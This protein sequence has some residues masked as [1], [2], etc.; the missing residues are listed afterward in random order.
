MRNRLF[1]TSAIVL[2]MAATPALAQSAPSDSAIGE[3]VVTAQKRSENIQ[4]VPIAISAFT[5]MALK[6][7]SVTSVASLSSLTPN[8]NLDGG[9]PFSGSSAVLSATIRGIGSDDFAFNIDP[10]VGIYLDGVY[11][12]RTVGANQDLPDVERVEILKGPQGTLFGRNTIG[13]A[14]SIV[15]HDPGKVFKG[16]FDATTGSF[17]MV[18]LRATVDVPLTHSLFS[19]LTVASLNRQGFL[20]RIPFP[21]Q[22][23]GN[24]DP[25]TSFSHADYSSASR[26]GGDNSVSLRGKLKWDNGGAITATFTGDFT[27]QDSPS[28][29][30]KLLGVFPNVPG[31][32][33]GTTNLPGTAF[34]PTSS[35]GFL[36]AGLY[37]FCIN[38]T[39]SQI[40]GRNA[41]GLCGP[42]GTQF[43]P[44]YQ[45]AGLGSVNT[46]S[47]PLNN[48]LPWDSR[49][50]IADPDL[51]YATG[52]SFTK[53]TA[54]GLGGTVQA[55]VS[56]NLTIKSITA[57]RQTNW[58]G[59]VDAD[60]SPLSFLEL[61]FTQ[62]Q[63]QLSQELQL[64]GKAFDKKLNYVLG[65]YYFKEKGD[66][67]D[68]VVFTEGLLQV[69]GLNK[70]NTENWAV[71]G[72]VDFRPSDLLGFTVGGRYTKERKAFEGGQQ[73]LNG[74][75]YKLFGCSDGAG[76]ITPGGPFPLA[77]VSCQ[78]ALGYPNPANPVQVYVPGV[79][80][81]SFSNFS[82]KLGVQ[83]HPA[84]DIMVYGSWSKG[85]KTGGWTTRLTNPQGNVAPDFNEEK[86]TTLE[87]GIKS[88]LLDRHLQINLAA[89]TTAYKGVQLNIQ[90]G[91]SPTIAN[92]G[93]ARI[94]G[95]EL[96][97]VAAPIRG[98]TINGA[99]GYIDAHYT[100]LLPAALVNASPIPGIQEGIFVGA[101][102]PKT[103]DWKINVSPRYEYRMASG[104]SLVALGDWTHT[105][106][107]WN[108]IAR[109]DLLRRPANDMFNASLAYNAPEGR[110]SI[111]LGA[112]NLTNT[113][114]I[115]SGGVN[116]AAGTA[117]G[118]YNR[119]REW[120]LRYGMKF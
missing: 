23:A 35:T 95:L 85:Y 8:V 29:A 78:T 86:A 55:E 42:R 40:A 74:G 59:G 5:A 108:D 37:N 49:F 114:Y 101:S 109:S 98:L 13:G 34:D 63:W 68:Y 116:I 9:T 76:N 4:T 52:P 46:D 103:A 30:T 102:L 88:S 111:T 41:Q 93:D 43:N 81:K 48:R 100:A 104:A 64:L 67:H 20:K 17:N 36:F 96:E 77:P 92:A 18:K 16:S 65:A 89:F 84:K 27:R 71:F 58:K 10:G 2:T 1:V 60:G 112:T 90:I 79:N 113:R 69:D 26:E 25:Y 14:I 106:Q 22:R 73:D 3:I 75:N 24:A 99:V 107:V 91:T 119:P 115:T 87:A 39:P 44:Q 80:R 33:A 66:L 19:S 70:F 7:R 6:E 47:N 117:F 53:L 12:A 82:P 118:T 31:P 61:S 62:N 94:K 120:Y 57:Y 110:Y 32:F 97:V 11:L 54:W 105:T 50:V 28:Q 38:S 72:Q 51:S 56:P 83:L 21:D 45:L 15:T